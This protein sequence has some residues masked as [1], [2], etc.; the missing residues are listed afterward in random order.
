MSAHIDWMTIVGRNEPD[1]A[2]LGVA[3]VYSR[4]S[5]W[6][7]AESDVFEPAM[8]S[9]LDWEIV[10]PRAPYAYARR[11]QDATRTL[12]VHPL[13]PHFALEVS[14]THCSRIPAQIPALMRDFQ[15]HFSRIDLA[16]DM[17][18]EV[19]PSE[20]CADLGETIVKTRA[21][22][23]SSTGE[24][25]YLGARS[26]ERFV[27][28][29]RYFPPHPRAHLLRAEFELKGDYARALAA[30]VAQGVTLGSLAA[31][32]GDHF[33]FQHPVWSDKDMPVTLK[34]TSHAQTGNTVAWLTS[35]IAPLHRRLEREGKLDVAAWMNSYV[36]S[37]PPSD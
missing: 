2:E 12:Y 1:K 7:D 29:Y 22:M 37:E 31:G 24:T 25:V 23:V 18:C 19:K 20:F 33:G 15:P 16:V 34:V 13:A 36:L 14:G 17:E 27:R 9:P 26:S 4:A 8:G 30:E 35:T 21:D 10:R 11:S 5:A 28:V 6:L 32:Q 3:A